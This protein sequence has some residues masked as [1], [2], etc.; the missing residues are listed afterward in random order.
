MTPPDPIPDPQPWLYPLARGETLATNDWCEWHFHRFLA[1]DFLTRIKHAGRRDAGFVAIELWSRS[2][3]EDPAGTLPD[4]DVLL[5]DRAGY[6]TDVAAW[7]EVRPYA[8][9]GWSPV[10]VD[11]AGEALRGRLG[12]R[13][14]AQ[15]AL[16][17]FRRKDGRRQA[18]EA[19]RLATVKHRVKGQLLAMGQRRF[20]ENGDLTETV[21]RHLMKAGLFATVENVAA[22]LQVLHGIPN[23]VPIRGGAMGD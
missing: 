2:Y 1:S 5:A 11:D 7:R 17:S 14:I 22:A 19:A 4:D 23:V 16:E 8:L 15:I 3:L 10:I 13:R 18:R 21:A 20:A 9:W 12:H 6:G